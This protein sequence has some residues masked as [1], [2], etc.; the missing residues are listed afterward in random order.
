MHKMAQRNTDLI[1]LA[2]KSSKNSLKRSKRLK[3]RELIKRINCKT[4]KRAYLTNIKRKR[5]IL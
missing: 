3:V 4:K 1:P 5:I 2:I